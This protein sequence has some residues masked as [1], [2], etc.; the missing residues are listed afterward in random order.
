[1]ESA[2]EIIH[3][4]L[5]CQDFDT[6][7]KSKQIILIF[8]AFSTDSPCL[9]S[10]LPSFLPSSIAHQSDVVEEAEDMELLPPPPPWKVM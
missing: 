2:G 7:Q 4:K 10:L 1:M 5:I 6:A 3:L 9:I 8:A